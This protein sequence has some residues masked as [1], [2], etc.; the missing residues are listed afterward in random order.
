MAVRTHDVVVIGAGSGGYAAARTSKDFHCDVA[1]VDPGPLGGL[2]ILRGCMP[3]KALIAT[4]DAMD[5]VRHSAQLGIQVGAPVADM[6]FVARRKRALVKEFADYRIAGIEEFP[7]YTGAATF[8]SENELAVGDDVLRAKTFVIATGSEITPAALPGLDETGY[9]DSDAVLELESIPRSAIVLGGGY[10]ACELGQFLSRMGAETTVLIR[11]GHLLTEADDDIGEALTGYF[12][13]EGIRVHERATMQKAFLRDGKK[14]VSFLE[15]GKEREVAAEEI[16]YALG[17]RPVVEGLGLERAGIRYDVKTG[18][19]VDEH[20][21]TT[22]PNVYA[23]GDVTG[24]YMLVHV[25]IYQGEVAARHACLGND[26]AADY[27]LVSAH[28]VFTDPQVAV[29]GATEKELQAKSVPYVSGRYDFAEHGKAQCLGKT[30]GFVKMMADPMSGKILGAAVIGPQGSELIHETIVAME[31][32][33]TVMQ[34]MRIPHL[35]PTLAEIWTY[36]AE[37]CASQIGARRP[38]DEQIEI[39]T[40]VHGAL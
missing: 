6:P 25:A 19:D 31:F 8:L 30:K 38:G 37:I 33:A 18:I 11:S 22:N 7:L 27:R 4:S 23:V 40:S 13:E 14:V 26:E 35:H 21:R 29:A 10:T 2:C 36:P 16:F 17:R 28:T 34:F 20:L 39:A 1:L 24:R 9:I 5:D 32:G 12:R 3:S 15:D